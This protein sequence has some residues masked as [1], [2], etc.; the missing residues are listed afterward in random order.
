MF[1]W[2][3]L[4]KYDYKTF[5]SESKDPIFIFYKI[6]DAGNWKKRDVSQSVQFHNQG[7]RA[8]TLPPPRYDPGHIT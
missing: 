4:H 5:I 8:G 1:H 6:F 2:E 7:N 3:S